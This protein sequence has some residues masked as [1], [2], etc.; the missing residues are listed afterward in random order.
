ML[1]AISAYC[2]LANLT[3]FGDEFPN[4]ITK[5]IEFSCENVTFGH[6]D[7]EW[8]KKGCCANVGW[9]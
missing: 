5:A 2:E 8:L 1:G 7:G 9:V 3:Y 6:L 4:H